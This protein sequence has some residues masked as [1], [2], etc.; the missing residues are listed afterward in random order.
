VNTVLSDSLNYIRNTVS[1]TAFNCNGITDGKYLYVL[2]KNE[3]SV[4]T[5]CTNI[6]VLNN[7]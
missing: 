5:V 7:K 4:I 2:L 1:D 3:I 6:K